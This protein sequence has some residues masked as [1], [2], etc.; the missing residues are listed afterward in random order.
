MSKEHL[1]A[2]VSFKHLH[3]EN[4]FLL[5]HRGQKKKKSTSLCMSIDSPAK[6]DCQRAENKGQ[7]LGRG[8][9]TTP[10]WGPSLASTPPAPPPY[11][12]LNHLHSAAAALLAGG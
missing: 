2:R 7:T 9:G 1:H 4:F 3:A 5:N 8:S 10:S 11:G 6:R 12:T